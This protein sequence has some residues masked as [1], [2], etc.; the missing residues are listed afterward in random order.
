MC[1]HYVILFKGHEDLQPWTLGSGN[2]E[3]NLP[4]TLSMPAHAERDQDRLRGTDSGQR[5]FAT[6]DSKNTNS[7][8]IAAALRHLHAPQ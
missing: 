8:A 7:A 5:F 3:A 4:R 1:K 2:S 6:T